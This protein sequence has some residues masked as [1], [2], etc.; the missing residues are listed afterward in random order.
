MTQLIKVG[1]GKGNR[2]EEKDSIN[3]FLPTDELYITSKNFGS[4]NNRLRIVF[5]F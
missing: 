2:D 1:R 5:D 4:R 3:V